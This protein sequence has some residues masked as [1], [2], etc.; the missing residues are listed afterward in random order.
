MEIPDSLEAL[1]AMSV[2]DL[3]DVQVVDETEPEAEVPTELEPEAEVPTE[4]VA[5]D[6]AEAAPSGDEVQAS[7]APEPA[8]PA[9][10]DRFSSI[11]A[12]LKSIE[13]RLSAERQQAQANKAPEFQPD[14]RWLDEQFGPDDP[15][16]PDPYKAALVRMETER[17]RQSWIYQQL[18]YRRAEESLRAEVNDAAAAHPDVPREWIVERLAANPTLTAKQVAEQI[19]SHLDARYQARLEAQKKAQ[20]EAPAQTPA[21]PPRPSKG[22]SARAGGAKV[23]SDAGRPQTLEELIAMHSGVN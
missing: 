14:L 16:A 15:D 2:D 11:E 10:S 23:A 9:E 20:A 19:Q 21:A 5:E 1:A 18:E 6:V 3:P 8:A 7:S 17:Q 13:Q 22:G 12:K 4:P